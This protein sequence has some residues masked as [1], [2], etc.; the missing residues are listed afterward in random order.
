LRYDGK[1]KNNGVAFSLQIH[2]RHKG[3]TLQATEDGKLIAQGA[4]EV[5]FLLTADT[6]YQMN[7]NPDFGNPQ[8]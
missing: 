6:D 1:L 2:A 5:V 7:F 8:T 3:G 4:D